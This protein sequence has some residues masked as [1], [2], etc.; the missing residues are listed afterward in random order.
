MVH[1]AAYKSPAESM[2]KPQRYFGN[3]AA[4]SALLMETLQDKGVQHLVFSST[5]AVYGTPDH[6]PVVEDAACGRRARTARARP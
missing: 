5:C 6:V 4:K 3:N 2:T 1:F